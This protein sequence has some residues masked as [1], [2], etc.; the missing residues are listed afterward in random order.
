MYTYFLGILK[1]NDDGDGDDDDDDGHD[2]DGYINSN[3]C[4]DQYS[5]RYNKAMIIETIDIRHQT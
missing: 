2:K 5:L 4:N 1:G 3:E